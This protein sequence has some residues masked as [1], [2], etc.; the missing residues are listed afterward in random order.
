MDGFCQDMCTSHVLCY[1][2]VSFVSE[3]KLGI[4]PMDLGLMCLGLC[5][6]KKKPP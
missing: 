6:H 4:N 2:K 1:M 5:G 3:G